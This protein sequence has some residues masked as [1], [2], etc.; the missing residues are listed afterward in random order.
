MP[1]TDFEK[2]KM[3]LGELLSINHFLSSAADKN[4]ATKVYSEP[5]NTDLYR[6][7]SRLSNHY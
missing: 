5:E 2:V 4:F 1:S 6:T 7:S 3:N